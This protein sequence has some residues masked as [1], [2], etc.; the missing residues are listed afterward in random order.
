MS[1]AASPAG[2]GAARRREP[3]PFDCTGTASGQ[4]AHG[5]LSAPAAHPIFFP[6]CAPMPPPSNHGHGVV[7]LFVL[8]LLAL[9]QIRSANFVWRCLFTKASGFLNFVRN[10]TTYTQ[11]KKFARIYNIFS[12]KSFIMF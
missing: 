8:D 1:R 4:G 10:K 2:N 11:S 5:K 7:I 12:N 3:S 9:W 6:E